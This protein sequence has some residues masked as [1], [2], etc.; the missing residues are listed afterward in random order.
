MKIELNLLTSKL[1]IMAGFCAVLNGLL[2]GIIDTSDV[3]IDGCL[4]PLNNYYIH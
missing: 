2:I 3:V 4:K 1:T